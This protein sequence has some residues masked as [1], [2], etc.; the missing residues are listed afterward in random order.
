VAQLVVRFGFEMCEDDFSHLR[1]GLTYHPEVEYLY[2][3]AADRTVSV[4]IPRS[5]YER[6]PSIGL[7]GCQQLIN[8]FC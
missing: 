4:W 2:Y 5:D 1:V 6:N 7:Q 3:I 8:E